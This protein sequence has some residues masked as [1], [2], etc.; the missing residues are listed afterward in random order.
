MKRLLLTGALALF[1]FA[2]PGMA[3]APAKTTPAKPAEKAPAKPA[4]P[5]P[6]AEKPAAEKPAAEKKADAPKKKAQGFSGK[7]KAVDA[8]KKTV[9][10]G[11]KVY[12]TTDETEIKNGEAAA[13]FTDIVVDKKIGGSYTADK[14]GTRTLVKINVGVK[15]D[16][17]KKTKEAAKPKADPAP[18]PAEPAKPNAADKKK[19]A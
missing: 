13:Q 2:L 12:L 8:E 11:D 3:Q 14:D 17:E 9:T 4:D 19:S 16:P 6:A 18:K 5:A 1:S 10:I 7:V 15:Q